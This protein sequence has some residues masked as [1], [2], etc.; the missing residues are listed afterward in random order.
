MKIILHEGNQFI[1]RLD[2][3]D[4]VVSLLK[5]FCQEEKIDSGFFYGLGACKS[6]KLSFYDLR[7]KKYI[8]K[9]FNQD[10]EIA[11]LVGNISQSGEELVVHMHGTF[12]DKEFKTFAGHVVAVEVG[13][14]CEIFVTK[15][16]H[17]VV[18]KFN[19]EVGIKVLD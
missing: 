17:F 18:R 15:F 4:E 12:S 8:E 1:L 16:N 9:E 13:V 11:N 3:G 6:L 10:L 7:L 5:K 19:P 2:R 14:T